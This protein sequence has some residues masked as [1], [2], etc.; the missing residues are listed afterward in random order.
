MGIITQMKEFRRD[1]LLYPNKEQ[2]VKEKLKKVVYIVG[3]ISIIINLYI[4][5]E[6]NIIFTDHFNV[7]SHFGKFTNY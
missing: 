3:N 6:K 4:H 7:Y 1:V 2:D 5:H